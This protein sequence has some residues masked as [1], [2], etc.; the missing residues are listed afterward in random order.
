MHSAGFTLHTFDPALNRAA[1]TEVSLAGPDAPVVVKLQCLPGASAIQLPISGPDGEQV[2]CYEVEAWAGEVVQVSL[3]LMDNGVPWVAASSR[4]LSLP[5]DPPQTP[6]LPL[7]P[8]PPEAPLDVAIAVD[9]TTTIFMEDTGREAGMR[10]IGLVPLLEQRGH[11]STH[12]GQLA[13]LVQ[14]LAGRHE[15]VNLT[16]FAFAD[17]RTASVEAEELQPEFVL[18]PAH[19][20]LER[21]SVTA[22]QH[23][24]LGF[25]ASPGGDFVDA[26][27]EALHAARQLNWQPGARRVLLISGNSPGHSVLHPAPRGADLHVRELDVDIEADRLHAMGVE[28]VTVF[29]DFSPPDAGSDP[30][31]DS[32]RKAREVFLSRDLVRDLVDYTREQYERLASRRELAFVTSLFD[33][34]DVTELLLA[35]GPG[36]RGATLGCLIEVA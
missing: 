11:W 25:E 31:T 16:A 19:P 21:I 2:A 18:R 33:P 29:H 27:A 35:T 6:R 10:E 30:E 9:A 8:P 17:H 1:E 13:A 12:T 28:I 23:R 4:V 36:G 22:L 7:L 26:L 24:L 5:V 32:A 15:D 20:R 34:P 3:R 14:A